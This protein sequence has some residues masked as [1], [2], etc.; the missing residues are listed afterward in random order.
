MNLLTLLKLNFN[1]AESGRSDNSL[2]VKSK[3]QIKSNK[4]KYAKTI[5]GIALTL[6]VVSVSIGIFF[7][8]TDII[9]SA[10][11]ASRINNIYASLAIDDDYTLVRSDIFGKKRVYEWDS[12]R[13]YSSSKTYT[14][15][16]DVDVTVASLR[17][18]IESAGFTYFEEPYPGSTYDQLH[19]KSENNEYIR[20]TVSSKPRD[21]ALKGSTSSDD[22]GFGINPN[23]GPSNV[24]IKVNLDDN[25]E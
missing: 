13:T 23:T 14:H 22:D 6:A 17:Q 8:V 18:K 12:G 2:M 11:R 5:Y 19:F 16:A 7:L 20:L 1:Y 25:N 9:P 21:A 10:N 15:D 4:R 3:K 24:T